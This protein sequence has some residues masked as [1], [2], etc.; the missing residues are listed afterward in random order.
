MEIREIF[1]LLRNQNAVDI[2][3]LLTLDLDKKSKKNN[4][5]ESKPTF[6]INCQPR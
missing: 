2:R 4:L 1:S 6:Y 5:I 3:T